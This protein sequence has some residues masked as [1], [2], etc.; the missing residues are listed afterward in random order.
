MHAADSRIDEKSI[1]YKKK[2]NNDENNNNEMS[3]DHSRIA[4]LANSTSKDNVIGSKG[5]QSPVHVL[6]F[7]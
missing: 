5:G 7:N 6:N 2:L 1:G 3:R 4:L